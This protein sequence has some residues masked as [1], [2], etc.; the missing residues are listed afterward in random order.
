[1]NIE[2]LKVK[3]LSTNVYGIINFLYDVSSNYD[4]YIYNGDIYFTK[5]KQILLITSIILSTLILTVNTKNE[6]IT[7]TD[8]NYYVGDQVLND[9]FDVPV[10]YICE[11]FK[12]SNQKYLNKIK[13]GVHGRIPHNN[14]HKNNLSVIL[15]ILNNQ[16]ID[17]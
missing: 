13:S 2:D 8:T 17:I 3:R 1:M 4:I 7:F 11:A 6:D 9:L 14:P 16:D 12:I 10:D 15:T 5:N